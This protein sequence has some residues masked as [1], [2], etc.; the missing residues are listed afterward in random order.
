MVCY[1]QGPHWLQELSAS[2]YNREF[3]LVENTQ[4]AIL[5]CTIYMAFRLLII[6]H[7]KWL[8]IVHLLI[9]FTAVFVLLEEIDYGHHYLNYLNDADAGQRS[10]NH[11]IHNLPDVNNQIRLVFY[12]LIAI[13]VII[14]PYF[15]SSGLPSWLVHFVADIRLQL[16]VLA[17][18]IISQVAGIFYALSHHTN[19]ALEGNISEFEE[20]PLYYL[21]WL[22]V[23]ML[24]R[25][26]SR[27]FAPAPQLQPGV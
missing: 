21:L 26:E 2:S 11:N 12:I 16:T 22:Y 3:G 18:L 9:F 13:F 17:F 1:F 5:L 15:S 23:Y 19:R 8:R 24:H 7:S 10:I 25:Q 6:P 14:L 4:N 27:H 20:L